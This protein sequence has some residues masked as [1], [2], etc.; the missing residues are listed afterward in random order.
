MTLSP[1]VYSTQN[2]QER[3]DLVHSDTKNV[4]KGRK[5]KW[6][7]T[8]IQILFIKDKEYLQCITLN[9]WAEEI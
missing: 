3:L 1:L 4:E 7:V 9:T 2:S 8:A 5:I 6:L